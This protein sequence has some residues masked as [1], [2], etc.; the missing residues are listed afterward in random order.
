MSAIIVKDLTKRLGKK[1]IL[2]GVNLEIQEGEFFSVLAL[3]GQGKTTIARILFN[4][5]KPSIGNAYIF[6]LDFNR[7][8][9]EI[10]ETTT[11]VPEEFLFQEN[12]KAVSLLK[13]TL[14]FHGL[15]NTEELDYLID[16][17]SFNRK[18]RINDMTENE[19]KIFSII[20]A[21]IVKPRVLILDE[22]AKGL[23]IEQ[24]V[25]VFDYLKQLQKEEGVTILMLTD[26]LIDA[27]NYCDRAA[28]LHD[29]N[30]KYTEYLKDKIANDKIIKIYSPLNDIN[31]FLEIGSKTIK[32]SPEEK[33]L[34][35]DGDMKELSRLIANLQIDNYSIEDSS[36]Y[37][38]ILAYYDNKEVAD[39][40]I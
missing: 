13:K 26:S 3:E 1:V 5:L 2:S 27:Q 9:K 33:I 10:K 40:D 25:K 8:S 23:S 15:K 4:Y 11:Y 31:P 18:I 12:I 19:K 20:N 28:Y 35:F 24:K 16:Y 6:D 32:N 36:L 38:K 39:S 29:G 22:P 37:D 34:Y 30:I 14:A 7:D 21:L 17:F